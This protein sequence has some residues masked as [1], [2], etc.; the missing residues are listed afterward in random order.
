MREPKYKIIGDGNCLFRSCSLFIY[1]TQNYHLIVRSSIVDYIVTNWDNEYEFLIIG[2]EFHK[3]NTSPIKYYH[4]MIKDGIYGTDLELS[5]FSK[6]YNVYTVVKKLLHNEKTFTPEEE[7]LNLAS[8]NSNPNYSVLIFRGDGNAGH[9]DVMD[10]NN[11]NQLMIEDDN[12]NTS[13]LKTAK[14]QIVI[15]QKQMRHY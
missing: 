8:D 6:L 14:I 11:V 5:A 7:E 13:L 9:Y 3:N 4:F 15:L 1:N 10:Y 2:N 12:E